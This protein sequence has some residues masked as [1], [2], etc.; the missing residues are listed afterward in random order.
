MDSYVSCSS[1]LVCI[2]V[3][4]CFPSVPDC[5]CYPCVMVHPW[6][7]VPPWLPYMTVSGTVDFSDFFFSCSLPFF[8]HLFLPPLPCATH[9][10]HP[11]QRDCFLDFGTLASSCFCT[12]SSAPSHCVNCVGNHLLL[13]LLLQQ[14]CLLKT[15]YQVK[16]T[17]LNSTFTPV[18]L[19][20]VLLE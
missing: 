2:Y 20:D 13:L 9:C 15:H 6:V 1:L 17:A 4:A 14:K 18:V 12:C 3:V 11:D 7:F 19:C 16:I 10:L 8:V 5:L